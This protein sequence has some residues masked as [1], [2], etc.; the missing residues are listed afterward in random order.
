MKWVLELLVSP[1]DT[2]S[3]EA[4]MVGGVQTG[5]TMQ[6]C[7]VMSALTGGQLR[8]GRGAGNAAS[9]VIACFEQS[10]EVVIMRDGERWPL[11]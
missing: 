5:L 1:M 11:L 2:S 3:E 8:R 7:G 4:I 9:C 6:H 10:M